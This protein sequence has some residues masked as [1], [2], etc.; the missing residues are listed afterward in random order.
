MQ[1][2]LLRRQGGWETISPFIV[3]V[4]FTLSH[5]S[6]RS[7]FTVTSRRLKFA[8]RG[9]GRGSLPKAGDW[10]CA[11]GITNGFSRREC[12]KCQAPAPPLPL[13]QSR[14]RL[15]GENPNDWACPCGKMNFQGNVNCF[16]CG[17]PKPIAP[18]AADA[19][20]SSMWQCTKCR[21]VTRSTQ[22]F[23]IRCKSLRDVAGTNYDI[24]SV[25][26]R[27]YQ[28]MLTMAAQQKQQST[29]E[30][31]LFPPIGSPANPNG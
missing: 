24:D 10:T 18:T 31:T 21:F 22:R 29:T 16:K 1:R 9:R 4:N 30:A 19:Q 28:E 17:M 12:F 20:A 3:R 13:G 5:T 8:K 7:F 15:P 6:H 23:C 14:P 26:A 27:K 2:Y 25:A 11:C